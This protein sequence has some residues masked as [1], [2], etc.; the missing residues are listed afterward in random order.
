[1]SS[2]GPTTIGVHRAD[3]TGQLGMAAPGADSNDRRQP[4]RTGPVTR[5]PPL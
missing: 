5:N 1:M 2:T 4:C 3:R